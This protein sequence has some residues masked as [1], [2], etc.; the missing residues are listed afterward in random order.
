[1]CLLPCMLCK[2]EVQARPLANSKIRSNFEKNLL[3]FLGIMLEV[4]ADVTEVAIF[5]IRVKN[6]AG[7]TTLPFLWSRNNA[8]DSVHEL[9]LC[10][11]VHL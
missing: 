2:T 1:M 7:P 3:H 9:I 10:I 5:A 11:Q 8:L 4:E 6:R